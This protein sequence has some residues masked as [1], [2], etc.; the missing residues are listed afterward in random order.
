[1]DAA[2]HKAKEIV[3][4]LAYRRD[5]FGLVADVFAR[6]VSE[7]TLG[8][9]IAHACTFEGDLDDSVE[10]VLN[11]DLRRLSCDDIGEFATQTRT[12]YARLFLGPR[13]VVVPLHES[14]YLSGTPRMF[15]AETLAVRGFY[16]RYGYV[17]K[18]KNR[19]PEDSIAV[20]FEFL[21]NLSDRCISR[22]EEKDILPS[23]EEIGNLLEAQ[24]L[25]KAQHLCRWAY[26][27]AQRVI[28][29]DQSGFYAAWATYL[30]G[31]LHED[32]ALLDECDRLLLEIQNSAC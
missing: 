25:F 1:M 13:R 7:E 2:T 24:K 16:E 9:M 15:T 8:Q 27:F 11:R 3:D 12:E 6:E 14:A 30:S 31:V 19:E 4:L 28:E 5:R 26:D 18:L 10:S 17:M 29:N 21:R 20:E 32:E 22:L 23:I